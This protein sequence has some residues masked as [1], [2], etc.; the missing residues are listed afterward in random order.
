MPAQ[1]RNLAFVDMAIPLG[2]GRVMMHPKLGRDCC[3]RLEINPQDK[4][5]EVST[6]G[7]LYDCAAGGTRRA[8]G[9][10]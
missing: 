2:H 10:R 9:E 4:I 5:L 6:G 8:R 7:V 1:Y 3:R